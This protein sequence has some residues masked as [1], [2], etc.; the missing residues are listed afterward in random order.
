MKLN[1]RNLYK[2]F[3]FAWSI[4]IGLRMLKEFAVGNTFYVITPFDVFF[5]WGFLALLGFVNLIIFLK[6]SY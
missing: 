6:D 2:I 4:G 5:D 3:L 1:F